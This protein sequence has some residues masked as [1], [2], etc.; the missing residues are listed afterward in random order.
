MELRKHAVK[1]CLA[2]LFAGLLQ[3]HQ[4]HKQK[5]SW[6]SSVSLIIVNVEFLAAFTTSSNEE[7]GKKC[8]TRNVC[9]QRRVLRTSIFITISNLSWCVRKVRKAS[10]ITNN[11]SNHICCLHPYVRP[12][13]EKACR[14][15]LG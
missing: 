13:V 15:I 4:V 2:R 3:I 5:D 14:P 1:V 7:D 6:V 11:L 9:S 10:D 8:L 12:R